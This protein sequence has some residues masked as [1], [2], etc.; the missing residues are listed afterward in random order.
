MNDLHNFT[1]VVAGVSRGCGVYYRSF[2]RRHYQLLAPSPFAS[3]LP[4]PTIP[5]CDGGDACCATFPVLVTLLTDVGR[6][7]PAFR[8]AACHP[9]NACDV[10]AHCCLRAYATSFSGVGAGVLR[11]NVPTT[12]FFMPHTIVLTQFERCLSVLGYRFADRHPPACCLVPTHFA[13]LDLYV[14]LACLVGW[15]SLYDD[16]AFMRRRCL[17][18]LL[19]CMVVIMVS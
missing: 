7:P 13:L 19:L 2:R 9:M 15:R 1:F 17:D 12:Q 3:F 4:T 8:A 10:C 6:L 11:W 18:D 14:L 5:Y 16:R